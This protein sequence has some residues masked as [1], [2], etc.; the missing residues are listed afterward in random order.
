MK[1]FYQINI[2]TELIQD[3]VNTDPTALKGA[4]EFNVKKGEYFIGFSNAWELSKKDIE[5]LNI[6]NIKPGKSFSING[7]TIYR[8]PNLSLPRQKVDLLKEK[9]NIKVIRDPNKADIHVISYKFLRNI[10]DFRWE[11]AISF[12]DFF[13]IIKLGVEEGLFSQECTEELKLIIK[14]AD[15]DSYV[16]LKKY[17]GYYNNNSHIRQWNDKFNNIIDKYKNDY[18]KV[19]IL[20]EKNKKAYEDFLNSSAEIVYD[21]DIL[22]I[23]DSELAVLEDD[24]YDN[25]MAM[26]TSSDRDNRTLGVEMLANCNIEKSFNIVSDLYW[27]HYDFI[28][29][30]NNW[31]SVNVKSLRNRMKG[32]EGGHSTNNIYSFNAYLNQLAKDGKLTKFAV[33]KT[34]EK[35]YKSLISN[36]CGDTSQVFKVD[37]ENLYIADELENMINE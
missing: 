23:I 24:Q 31:N 34:R 18:N 19:I 2:N 33:D 25:I 37:L 12:V 4:V 7:K 27:W 36:I 10:F 26:I 9:E 20:E 16:S 11:N 29:D 3:N 5:N 17:Y 28:K 14:N 21:T 35:L 32:Y 15:K 1:T 30:T 8:F 6:P 22:D 13:N